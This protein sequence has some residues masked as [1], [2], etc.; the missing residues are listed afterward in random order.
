MSSVL[1]LFRARRTQRCLRHEEKRS[2]RDKKL[3]ARAAENLVFVAAGS[4]VVLLPFSRVGR[5]WSALIKGKRHDFSDCAGWKL[6]F[7]SGLR[8]F[9]A[10]VSQSNG[11]AEAW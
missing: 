9:A 8:D 5:D 11:L 1:R 7:C 4:R 6:Q 2:R 10:E 3:A